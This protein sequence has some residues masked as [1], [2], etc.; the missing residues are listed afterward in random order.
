MASLP[1]A[2]ENSNLVDS[3]SFSK[4]LLP[5]KSSNS[6]INE[7][8][9]VLA[10]QAFLE[11]GALFALAV[12]AC[13]FFATPTALI[14]AGV[15]VA[16]S[17]IYTIIKYVGK[18]IS[19]ARANAPIEKPIDE[20]ANP[21]KA[22]DESLV[23]NAVGNAMDLASSHRSLERVLNYLNYRKNSSPDLTNIKSDSS[24]SL[25]Y[26]EGLSAKALSFV[27]RKIEEQIDDFIF[28][29]SENYSSMS[30]EDFKFR[31]KS[32]IEQLFKNNPNNVNQKAKEVEGHL[33]NIQNVS[34]WL[35]YIQFLQ[36]VVS[37]LAV[38]Q[39]DILKNAL[40][41]LS[42]FRTV[43][44]SFGTVFSF[45]RYQLRFEELVAVQA[46]L[47]VQ[48][49]NYS[50]A[51]T[52]EEKDLL[53]YEIR[54]NMEKLHKLKAQLEKSFI[55]IS[56]EITGTILNGVETFLDC[57]KKFNDLSAEAVKTLSFAHAGVG[58]VGGIYATYQSCKKLVSTVEKFKDIKKDISNYRGRVKVLEER[59]D[60]VSKVAKSHLDHLYAKKDK[61]TISL[62]GK[63]F[64]LFKSILTNTSTVFKI[65]V[66]AGVVLS[67]GAAAFVSALGVITLVLSVS[68][69]AFQV[70]LALYQNRHYIAYKL[71]TFKVYCKE[72]IAKFRSRG[73]LSHQ[74]EA[75]KKVEQA[76]QAL[77]EY[78]NQV[79]EARKGQLEPE[80]VDLELEK[81][82]KRKIV[83]IAPAIDPLTVEEQTKLSVLMDTLNEANESYRKTAD[84]VNQ[85]Y[86]RFQK[87]SAERVQHKKD[88]ELDKLADEFRSMDRKEVVELK[89]QIGRA[90]NDPI[91][92][93]ELRRFF[94]A[95]GFNFKPNFTEED[96]MG[97]ILA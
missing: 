72:T 29:E 31:V 3:F 16:S 91:Q 9:K 77:L 94:K 5:S 93:E 73:E 26:K 81:L 66:L 51:K 2:V 1:Q 78:R 62:V 68:I 84:K 37:K 43:M 97:Y 83:V 54:V 76:E 63:V 40:D 53:L 57:Y 59:N 55:S 49:L 64:K 82:L 12:T 86:A 25:E 92:Q 44:E 18:Y 74:E 10:K 4:Y 52:Q 23:Q 22:L 96:V 50:E 28:I 85:T 89:E 88:Y 15:F 13:A 7:R 46:E 36:K 60:I 30:Q 42:I 24:N 11:F 70:A 80:K 6:Q 8:I 58:L 41:C 38:E 56:E 27:G 71:K 48:F 69:M 67:S 87:F 17:L 14:V 47:H 34:Q 75:L 45:S 19:Q 21:Q 90:V 39:N 33:E 65:I 32:F 95:E 35:K 20:K 61:E 79:Y